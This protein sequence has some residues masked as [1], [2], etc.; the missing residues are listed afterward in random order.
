MPLTP[1][2]TGVGAAGYPST[3]GAAHKAEPV[4]SG[5]SRNKSLL[6]DVVRVSRGWVDRI[7]LDDPQRQRAARVGS[8]AEDLL[9]KEDYSPAAMTTTRAVICVNCRRL[10]ASQ[11]KCLG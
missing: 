7:P 9:R 4:E 11:G 3:S 6:E 5:A 2:V 8:L 1:S 10:N